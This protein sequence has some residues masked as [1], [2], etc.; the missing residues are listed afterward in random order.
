[1]SFQNGR[2]V[3]LVTGGGRDKAGNPLP[4]QRTPLSG[5]SLAP[6]GSDDP[7]DRSEMAVTS[8]VMRGQG[9]PPHAA[10]TARIEVAGF[11]PFD[12]VWAFDGEIGLFESP[13]SGWVAGWRVA[14]KR[15]T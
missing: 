2:T 4:V 8:A 14:L 6:A 15:V 13:F 1:M 7:T 5:V 3:T 10:S 11:F 9:S 12:G